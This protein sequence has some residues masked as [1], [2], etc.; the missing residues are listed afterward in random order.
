MEISNHFVLNAITCMSLMIANNAHPD[1][2]T[3]SYPSLHGLLTL[4]LWEAQ[5]KW[6]NSRMDNNFFLTVFIL[7]QWMIQR[8]FTRTPLPIPRF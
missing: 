2:I 5:V 6:V 1:E 3:A 7:D 4:H 8:G